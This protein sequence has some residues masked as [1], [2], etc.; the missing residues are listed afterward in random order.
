MQLEKGSA[1]INQTTWPGPVHQNAPW[2]FDEI[3][4]AFDPALAAQT[5][6]PVGHWN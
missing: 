3:D 6:S 1:K 2:Y 5:G 4:T